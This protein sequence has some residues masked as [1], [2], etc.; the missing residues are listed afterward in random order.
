LKTGYVEIEQQSDLD[1][2]QPEAGQELGGVDFVEVANALQFDDDLL[3]DDE[4]EAEAVVEPVTLVL[5]RDQAL[6][7]DFESAKSKL[8][9]KANAVHG[10][11]EPGPKL[12]VNDDRG[13]DHQRRDF[14]RPSTLHPPPSTLHP[15]PA[16]R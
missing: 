15:P 14:I 6:L 1:A 2:C 7:F 12:A 16:Q 8:V 5:H 13:P 11:E 10:F 3:A 4:V 9:R